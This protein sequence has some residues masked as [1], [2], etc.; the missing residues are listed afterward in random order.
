MNITEKFYLDYPKLIKLKDDIDNVNAVLLNCVKSRNKILV[1]GN[2]GSA[3]DSEHIVGE[4][5]KGF[6]LPR[7]LDE[8]LK[9]KFQ[10]LPDANILING[11]QQ[12]IPAISLVSQTSLITAIAN[13]NHADLI[14][15]QQV[16]GYGESD[17][18]LIALSTSGN[19]KNVYLAAQTAKA[20]N[21]KIITI[22]GKENSKLS[23]ISDITIKLPAQ[24][25]YEVQEFTLPLY[26]YLCAELEN[27]LFG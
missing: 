26:H 1:C 27:N 13:D 12:A 7:P 21:M 15:A 11:L 22:T 4:L 8:S 20:L 25:P 3:S 14:F 18:V 24:T 5:M 17:D 23:E 19:S 16:F 2:G 9:E 10:N 6:N